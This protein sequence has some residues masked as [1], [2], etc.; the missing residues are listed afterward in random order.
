MNLDRYIRELLYLED[1]VILP[2]LGGF[3]SRYVSAEIRED[4][5]TFIPPAKEIV[6]N[7]ELQDDDGLFVGFVADCEGDTEDEVRWALDEKITRI[8]ASLHGGEQYSIEGVGYFHRSTDGALVFKPHLG[9]NFLVDSYGFTSFNFPVLEDDKGSFLLRNQIFRQPDP[10]IKEV[11]PGTKERKKKLFKDPNIKWA[12]VMIPALLLLSII[13]YNAR[14]S[15]SIF[16][17]PASLGP[18]P[19]LKQIAPPLDHD[20]GN[21]SEDIYVIPMP[22]LDQ[23]VHSVI[24]E[25]QIQETQAEPQIVK[26][27]PI[28]AGSFSSQYN[29][30]KMIRQINSRGFTADQ[31]HAPNGLIRVILTSFDDLES[32]QKALPVLKRD[33]PD[34]SLWILN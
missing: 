19:A 10:I 26:E 18:L 6:F 22:V 4:S 29:A 28:I 33:H 1:C 32:A 9:T 23:P 13:P 24:E 27:Y 14:I 30:N 8:R 15:E 2:G 34:F 31:M 20:N 12:A 21:G 5:Q 7:A 3:V 11:L 16:S 17:H 25:Q